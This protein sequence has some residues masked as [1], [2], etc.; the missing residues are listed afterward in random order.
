MRFSVNFV[1]VD[2]GSKSTLHLGSGAAEDNQVTAA[3]VTEDLEALRTEPGGD[4]VKVVLAEPEAIG[5]LLRG[6]P[7]VIFRRRGVLLVRQQLVQSSLLARRGRRQQGYVPETGLGV[8]R[9]LVVLRLRLWVQAFCQ[10]HH[11]R[12]I[13]RAGNAVRRYR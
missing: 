10:L 8:H 2:L 9:A 12:S 5:V 1:V 11:P 4:F 6:K 7:L 13:N 3:P